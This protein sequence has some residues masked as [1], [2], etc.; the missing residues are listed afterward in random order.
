MEEAASLGQGI[1]ASTSTC[2]AG[3]LDGMGWADAAWLVGAFIILNVVS[4]GS[5]ISKV[6]V[7]WAYSTQVAGS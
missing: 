3:S 5:N 6:R 1:F 2:G 7:V 4:A